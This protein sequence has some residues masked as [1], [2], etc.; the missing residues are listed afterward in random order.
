MGT[1][2]FDTASIGMTLYIDI[3]NKKL[4]QSLTSDRSVPLPVFMQGDNEPLELH[5][6]E[7]GEENLY[8]EKSLVVGTD[9]LKVAIARF[10]GTP[11]ILTFTS[12]YTLNTNGVADIVLP[13]NTTAIE[14][15]VEE[16]EYISAFLE[17]EY[18]NSEGKI[19]TILQTACRVKNDLIDN[20][21]SV[22]L[23]ERYYD[24]TELDMGGNFSAIKLKIFG[25]N[26][27]GYL[28]LKR[29]GNVLYP[30]FLTKEEYDNNA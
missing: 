20:A 1:G 28:V 7:K 8:K 4:V 5:L 10:K 9:F 24:K 13:L 16:N 6:L 29:N 30:E 15:A 17:V 14:Q 23:Q 19:I 27:Y 22:E 12:D 3:E 2:N 26:E 18:S 21:P 11:K 25:T